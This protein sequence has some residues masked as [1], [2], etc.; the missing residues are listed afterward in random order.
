MILERQGE[1]NVELDEVEVIEEFIANELH[2]LN[3]DPLTV[4]VRIPVAVVAEW[5]K[6]AT[7][8][9]NIGT[10]GVSRRLGQMSDEGQMKRLAKVPGRRHGRCFIWAGENADLFSEIRNDVEERI[11]QER[12]NRF[13]GGWGRL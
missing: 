13:G 10:T 7:G 12:D 6:K 8:D 2:R 1:A 9:R 3:Y 4:Q 11:D 5:Y